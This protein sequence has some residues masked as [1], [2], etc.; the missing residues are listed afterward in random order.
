MSI[1]TSDIR[2]PVVWLYKVI[3]LSKYPLLTRVKEP[4][5][6]KISP[7]ISEKNKIPEIQSPVA[8]IR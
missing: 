1:R 6:N 3:A 5:L 4:N 7:S 2:L 8:F